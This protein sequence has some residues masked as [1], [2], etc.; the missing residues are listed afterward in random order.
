MSEK[1][2]NLLLILVVIIVLAIPYF[3]LYRP[4]IEKVNETKFNI[5]KIEQ[6][7]ES[8]RLRKEQLKD[9]DKEK[10]ILEFNINETLESLPPDVFIERI[11]LD[12]EDIQKEADVRFDTESFSDV[13]QVTDYLQNVTISEGKSPV[14][15]TVEL[16]FRGTYNGLKNF[17][18]LISEAHQN[19][20]ID[21][22]SLNP[23]VNTDMTGSIMLTYFA[24][25]D[26]SL[27]DKIPEYEV[28]S[29]VGKD[30]IFV[31]YDDFDEDIVFEEDDTELI[32]EL[33]KYDF[34]IRL[35][36]STGVRPSVLVEKTEL[37][38]SR[39]LDDGNKNIDVEIDILEENG[40]YF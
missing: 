36:P 19:M 5:E 12:I 24:Y 18:Y 7:I 40:E 35:S 32:I 31:P 37:P 10:T 28:K 33:E 1:D 25:K 15:M 27:L 39:A 16:D 26:V 29:D 3:A 38:L 20:R 17:L 8:I 11:L 14:E 22:I 4:Y 23:G 34:N 30:N 13:N 6:E 2:K 21:D 9:S